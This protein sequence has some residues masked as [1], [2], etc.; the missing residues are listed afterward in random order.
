MLHP[1]DRGENGEADVIQVVGVFAIVAVLSASLFES[2]APRPPHVSESDGSTQ[3]PSHR[4]T[5]AAWSNRQR[6]IVALAAIGRGDKQIAREL[7]VSIAT[8]KTHLH[9]LYRDHGIPN[10]SAAV[11]VL[12]ASARE[13]RAHRSRDRIASRH[14]AQT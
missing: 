3:V 2:L 6:T 1:D 5:T 7:G 11:A 8:V 4:L 10:R 14:A 12:F 13:E 9:R